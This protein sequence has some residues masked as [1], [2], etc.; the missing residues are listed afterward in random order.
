MIKQL[1]VNAHKFLLLCV[2]V[3][4]N[5]AEWHREGLAE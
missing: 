4:N 2:N 1:L 5:I 3:N